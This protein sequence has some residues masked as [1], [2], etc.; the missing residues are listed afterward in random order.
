MAKVHNGE[1]ILPKA[2]TTRVGRTNVTDDRRICDNKVPNIRSGKNHTRSF[3][4][5]VSEC[6]FSAA[7]I[8]HTSLNRKD[9]RF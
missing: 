5:K 7:A 6:F 1:E 8:V 2:S 9:T 3:L 4:H